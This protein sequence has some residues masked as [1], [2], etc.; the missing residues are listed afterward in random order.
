MAFPKLK[1]L[2]KPD[3]T[4]Q[5]PSADIPGDFGASLGS[6]GIGR[7]CLF[8]WI[9]QRGPGGQWFFATIGKMEGDSVHQSF[10]TRGAF[11]HYCKVSLI[12]LGILGRVAHF[13]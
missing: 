9:L 1:K 13:D 7:G 4:L 5:T 2:R 12:A 8:R 11:L 10:L 3:I 6:I